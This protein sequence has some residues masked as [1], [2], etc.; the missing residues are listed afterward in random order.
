MSWRDDFDDASLDSTKFG[1]S[2][3]GDGAVAEASGT[4]NITM[5]AATANAALVY[6]KD[7]LVPANTF[8]Y[9]IRV[10][11]DG[12][13]NGNNL[14]L[15]VCDGVPSARAYDANLNRI[16]VYYYPTGD[17]LRISYRKVT[18]GTWYNWGGANKIWTTSAVDAATGVGQQYL[19]DVSILSVGGQFR[20]SIQAFGGTKSIVETDW[21][22]F[23]DLYA[24]T[25]LYWY[26]GDPWKDYNYSTSMKAEFVR[27]DNETLI[28]G[29]YDGQD[30]TVY[31][32]GRCISFD[33][34][35]FYFRDPITAVLAALA[36]E[37]NVYIPYTISQGGT[38]HMFYTVLRS[39]DPYN[40]M[41]QIRYATSTD[42]GKTYT[43][44]GY[45]TTPGAEG[46]DYEKGHYGCCVTYDTTSSRW[47]MYVG[48]MDASSVI[49]VGY[50]TADAPEGPW[51][52]Y[53]TGRIIEIGGAG[54]WN[55]KWMY[56]QDI[57]V[58]AGVLK[59]YVGGLR[60]STSKWQMGLYTSTDWIT[61]TPDEGNPVI[62]RNASNQTSASNVT[63]GGVT[64]TVTSSAIF[65]VDD[66]V[67]IG[68]GTNRHT[69]RILSIG[70]GTH[71]TLY[72]PSPHAYTT[73]TVSLLNWGSVGAD[74]VNGTVCFATSHQMTTQIMETTSRW[75]YSAGTWLY[76]PLKSPPFPIGSG[77]DSIAAESFRWIKVPVAVYAIVDVTV[78]A[79]LQSGSK[80]LFS[81]SEN[82][83]QV[84]SQS[85]ISKAGSLFAP[86]FVL[87][88]ILTQNLQ[89]GSNTI[90]QASNVTDQILS[91]N[92][93]SSITSVL[94]ALISTDQV[95]TVGLV[96][97]TG[98]LYDVTVI[99]PIGV[100]VNLGLL[101]G[102]CSVLSSL[103]QQDQ[104]LDQNL[105]SAVATLHQL[106]V[107][108]DNFIGLPN[109]ALF[110]FPK[111]LIDI[112]RYDS[113]TK[114]IVINF[115]E[116]DFNMV[117]DRA[118]EDS[119]SVAQDFKEEIL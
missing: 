119:S 4:V 85:L 93:L 22:N 92:L 105:L 110:G 86:S 91:Q 102:I 81:V 87:D 37:S 24:Y 62:A 50:M 88:Q 13:I 68:D 9:T 71:I 61:L 107:E 29:F 21:I 84:L 109:N 58:V 55:D 11:Q 35:Y 26:W 51:T 67:A 1:T 96:G 15:A 14:L 78:N 99:L 74:G 59:L 32:I 89:A 18:T 48:L 41:Y 72:Y 33:G 114:D 23:S 63:A 64:L 106:L 98:S 45:I 66:P 111:E 97:S 90:F 76:K 43:D 94:S 5:G 95:L 16:Q 31:A 115:K 118:D 7:A 79:E 44:Q 65:T 27:F 8:A 83:D 20:I 6:L 52:L 28:T 49:M 112:D 54:A 104:I 3:A 39:G 103:V 80:S 42:D 70:D 30:G 60:D 17:S 34:G 38:L 116:G 75:E 100:T 101:L 10:K 46:T 12:T 69:N 113:P 77:W 2:V 36:G 47:K 117:I 57:D 82:T 53:G 73:P 56:P 108:I 40:G 19:I 25:T